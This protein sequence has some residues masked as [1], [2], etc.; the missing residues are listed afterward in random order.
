MLQETYADGAYLVRQGEPGGLL[1]VVEAGE[2]VC[3]HRS[4]GDLGDPQEVCH[5]HLLL[6]SKHVCLHPHAHVLAC[7]GCSNNTSQ[8]DNLL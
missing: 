1:F 5:A 3:M 7:A 6:A 2:V 4:T 8:P